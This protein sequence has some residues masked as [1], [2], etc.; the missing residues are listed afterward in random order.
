[1]D[2]LSLKKLTLA[3][4]S[5]TR[6]IDWSAVYCST[7]KMLIHEFGHSFGLYDGYIAKT[8]ESYY[9]KFSS[10]DQPPSIMRDAKCFFIT[11]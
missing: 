11:G 6:N 7:Y 3:E 8:I 9:T 4:V 1:M 10:R 2:L 5:A